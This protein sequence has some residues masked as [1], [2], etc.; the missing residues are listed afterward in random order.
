MTRRLLAVAALALAATAAP[1]AAQQAADV[2]VTAT[3]LRPLAITAT[4][5]AFNNVFPG[6][7]KTVLATDAAPGRL[8]I[9][10]QQNAQFTLSIT[11]PA[12]LVNGANN[13]PVTFTAC[14]G[15]TG[16]T[17]CTPAAIPASVTARLSNTGAVGGDGYWMQIGGTV[18]PAANQVAGAYSALINATVAYTGL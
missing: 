9:L 16:V 6:V 7:T 10:G 17:A 2:S 8:D 13:L 11:V 1:A 4:P 3:V 12:N 14:H 5:L 15:M 18:V